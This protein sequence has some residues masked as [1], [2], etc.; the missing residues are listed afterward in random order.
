[1]TRSSK[2][3]KE[4]WQAMKMTSEAALRG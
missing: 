1:M 3:K 2:E 4:R